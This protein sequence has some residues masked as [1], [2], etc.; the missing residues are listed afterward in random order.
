[1]VAL[2]CNHSSQ[3]AETGGSNAAWVTWQDFEK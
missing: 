1:M 3:E 2:A